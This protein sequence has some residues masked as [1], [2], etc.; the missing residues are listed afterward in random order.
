MPTRRLKPVTPGTRWAVLPDFSEI[1]RS[2]GE[3]SLMEPLNR[4]AG[5]NSYGR[6]TCRH[7]GGG[8]KRQYRII[9]F[10]RNKFDIPGRID[11]IEY[12]PN[13][14]ARIALVVYPD[15]EKRYILAPEGLRVGQTIVSG[16]DAAPEVGNHLPLERIPLGSMI[17]NVELRPGKG[18]QIA[19]SAGVSVQLLARE[20]GYATLR[21]PSREMRMVPLACMATL[22]VVGNA[23]HSNISIG[24]AGRSRWLGRR[25]SVRGVA[26]NP[27]DHPMGG[28]EGKSSGGRHP[29]SPW[30]QLAKGLKTR[31]PKLSDK[32]I[33]RR[34]PTGKRRK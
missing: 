31:S 9:D 14:S 25:P 17:H 18:G 28:G 1:T 8:H 16:R 32:L 23:D 29:C 12:D 15:G 34:R 5:R 2:R 4:K 33:T 21:M 3:K 27:I 20:G 11:A 19:R 30:G 13:R 6:I 26:M 7:K 24:K 10:K 22:G